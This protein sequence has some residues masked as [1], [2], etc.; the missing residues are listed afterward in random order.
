MAGNVRRIRPGTAA[1]T[2]SRAVTDAA[3]ALIGRHEIDTGTADLVADPSDP[4]GFL[5][6][7]NDVPSSYVHADPT[8][9]DFEY[10]QWFGDVLE[11]W[12]PAPGPLKVTHVG[13]AG[14]TM[15]RFVAA[16]RPGSTQVVYEIDA[17]LAT[18]ARQAFGLKQVTGVRIR[19]ADGRTG[20]AG[21]PAGVA[22]VVIRDA[23]AGA[24]VPPHL[25]TTGW[26]DVVR[27]ALAPGGLYIANVADQTQLALARREAVTAAAAF[28]HVALVAEPGQLRGRRYGNVVLLASDAALPEQALT[29]RLAS[30]AVR[31]RYVPPA[32]VAELTSGQVLLEDPV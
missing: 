24:L 3:N 20:L 29:R 10:M 16:T 2:G 4:D 23:F 27:A 6:S 19:A 32:R 8:R 1:R 14:C 31:A 7:V 17:A 5:L 21:A 22:D 30:G 18:L 12:L 13:G 9:L 26:L 25:T 28:T 11:A 15:A